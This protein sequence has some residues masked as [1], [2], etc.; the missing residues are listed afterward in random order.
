MRED[1][2]SSSTSLSNALSARAHAAAQFLHDLECIHAIN[3]Y[4]I[5]CQ[6]DIL[7]RDMAASFSGKARSQA[8][9]DVPSCAT[10]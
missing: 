7:S 2:S 5:D 6:K 3:S 9:H 4:A 10:F 8:A 1:W